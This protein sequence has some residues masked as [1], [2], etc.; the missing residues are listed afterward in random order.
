MSL[1]E[2]GETHPV[3]VAP[4]VTLQGTSGFKGGAVVLL[5][6]TREGIQSTGGT[7]GEEESGHFLCACYVCCT[8]LGA[9]LSD[10]L[11]FTILRGQCCC[12]HFTDEEAEAQRGEVT[13][14]RFHGL[15]ME[16]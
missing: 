1:S 8:R 3:S 6:K 7:E 12:L 16:L 11:I 15:S 2:A 4:E 5:G 14:P 9:F 10:F 13:W